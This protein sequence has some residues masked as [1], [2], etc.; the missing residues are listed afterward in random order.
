MTEH[1]GTHTLMMDDKGSTEPVNMTGFP[2]FSSIKDNADEAYAI[3]SVP[4]EA[5]TQACDTGLKVM[6]AV[7][8][9]DGEALSPV[10]VA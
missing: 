8:K 1:A 9:S 7:I 3:V 10:C 2:R 4:C 6:R 5:R